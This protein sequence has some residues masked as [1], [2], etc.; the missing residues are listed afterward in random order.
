MLY[1]Q[2]GKLLGDL[3]KMIVLG[4]ERIYRFI[5]K[6]ADCKKAVE[7]LILEIE[8]ADWKT[9]VD[10]KSRYPKASII[11][12]TNVVFNLCGNKYR[13][14]LKFTYK[15]AIALI[16]KIGTHKEYDTWEIV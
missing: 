8:A 14:W 4:K 5:S 3:I 2:Y 12:N 16:I 11:G 9:P 10:I 7:I 1:S 15:N 13:A 6:H